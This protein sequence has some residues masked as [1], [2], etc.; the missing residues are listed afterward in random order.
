MFSVA[1][2]TLDRIPTSPLLSWIHSS[3]CKDKNSTTGTRGAMAI[4]LA[5]TSTLTSDSTLRQFPLG[6]DFQPRPSP[7]C[8]FPMTFLDPS[9]RY[10]FVTQMNECDTCYPCFDSLGAW[11]L[12]NSG[13]DGNLERLAPGRA[14]SRRNDTSHERHS[15]GHLVKSLL[16]VLEREDVGAGSKVSTGLSLFPQSPCTHTMPLVLILPLSRRSMARGKQ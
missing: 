8:I 2:C 1:V 10:R 12:G 15:R 9:L 5:Q 6:S 7:I 11:E 16:V 13:A 4:C 14:V 3:A